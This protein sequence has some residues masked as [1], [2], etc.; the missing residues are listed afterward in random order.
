MN[1]Q[2]IKSIQ[3]KKNKKKITCLTAYTTS[4]AK[5]IDNY[6]DM[7]LI[8]DSLGM[9]IYGMKNTQSVSLEMMMNHGKAVVNSSKKAFTIIDMPYNTYK[10]SKDALINSRK[11]LNFTKCQ[12]IKIEAT[13]KDVEIVKFLKKKILMLFHILE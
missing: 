6:V 5:I 8:G 7:I 11:L 2:T 3:L 4:L 12:S 1:R 13:E 9:A 10:N